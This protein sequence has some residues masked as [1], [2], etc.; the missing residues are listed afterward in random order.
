MKTANVTEETREIFE[1]RPVPR[2]LAKMAIPTIVSQLITLVYNIADTWFIGQTNNP[3]MVAAS[4]LVLTIFLMTTCIAN[5]FGVGGGSLV[6]RL[7]GR[8]DGDEA[9]KVAS[10]SLVM[11][12]VASLVFSILCLIFMNPLLRLLGASDNTIGFA[13]QY[14]MLVVVIG[15]FPTVMANT[16]SSMVRNIGYSK[17]AGFGL[18]MG[19]VLNVILDP[20]FMFV[21]LPDGYQVVGAA[22]ATML[23]NVITLVYFIFVYKKLAGETVLA[24][25]RSI[26]KIRRESMGSLFSVGIPAAMSL[27]LFDL[28]NMVINRLASGHGD[29]ELAAIG[30][31]LKVERLPLNIGIGICLGMTPLVA[32]NYASKN[33]KR[34]KDFFRTAR[35]VGLIVSV[36]C[37]VFYRI[38]APYII[39]AFISDA[40]T[41][42][43][44]TQFLQSRC[45]ATP[46]MFLSFHMV[47][48]MQAVDRGKVSFLL[49]VIR[50]LFLNIP[51]L[52][53]MNMFFGM[54]GIVWTQLT[55]DVINVVISYVIYARLIG[56][57]AS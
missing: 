47:H 26:E 4:S 19:G 30:I 52:F 50:Q 16:M 34:M 24:L 44:G 28:C 55:A 37:V 57:I 3:Y 41:V 39:G 2:A 35:L 43:F 27:L 9:R 6:V 53:L 33:H 42:R 49:A 8:N 45:F 23:S 1:T 5:L 10:L 56:D 29:I 7:L 15:C 18:G 17:E 14:L 21:I 40:D 32:Y 51:I 46:F 11:A 38:C 12:A 31:V 20:I 25:P 22:M 13:R 48:F 36:L 54:N